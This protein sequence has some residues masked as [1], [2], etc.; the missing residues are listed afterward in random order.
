MGKTNLIYALRILL[1]RVFSDYDF[2]LKE[3]YFCAYSDA[4]FSK[5]TEE[6]VVSRLAGKISDD[7]K[8]IRQYKARLEN[9]K[10]E[11]QFF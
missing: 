10:V 7:D 9:G 2:E 1:D 8:F 3:S 4:Y 5:L 6:C 11:Y